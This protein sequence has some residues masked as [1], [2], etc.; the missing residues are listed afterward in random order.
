MKVWTSP[1]PVTGNTTFYWLSQ[2]KRSWTEREEWEGRLKRAGG[3]LRCL[4]LLI[5]L[6]EKDEEVAFN[7]G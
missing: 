2:W 7:L 3:H 4:F 5:K 6:M 1:W